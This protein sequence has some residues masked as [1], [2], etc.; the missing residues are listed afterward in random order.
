V[1]SADDMVMYLYSLTWFEAGSSII[2]MRNLLYC[3]GQ[4]FVM[5][6]CTQ[7]RQMPVPCLILYSDLEISDLVSES[8]AGLSFSRTPG[9]LLSLTSHLSFVSMQYPNINNC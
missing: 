1:H 8:E 3:G 5:C 6:M 7:E 2:E 4:I 9:Q